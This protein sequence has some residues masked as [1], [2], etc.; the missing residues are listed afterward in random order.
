MVNTAVCLVILEL[1]SPL[2]KQLE[3]SLSTIMFVDGTSCYDNSPAVLFALEFHLT[4][5]IYKSYIKCTL[6]VSSVLPWLQVIW[7][8]I[9]SST[10]L[11]CLL[12]NSVFF[13]FF[14]VSVIWYNQPTISSPLWPLFLLTSHSF[15]SWPPLIRIKFQTC[16]WCV[17]LPSSQPDGPHKWTFVLCKYCLTLIVACECQ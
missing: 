12:L 10:L 5:K 4:S 14:S 3:A 2:C 13:F 15:P 11:S 8:V 7:F 9:C 16:L 17:S 6:I 1:T